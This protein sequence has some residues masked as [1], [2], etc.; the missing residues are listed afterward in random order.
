LMT[1]EVEYPLGDHFA[2]TPLDKGVVY[3]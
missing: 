3:E 2:H 1:S